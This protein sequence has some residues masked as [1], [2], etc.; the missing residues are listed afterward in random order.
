MCNG[1]TRRPQTEIKPW[2]PWHG[3][4]K[5]SEGCRN[6][7]VY[8][9]DD[10]HNKSDS[11]IVRKNADF[12]LPVR[13]DKNGRFKLI[14]GRGYVFTCMTSDFFV[15][16]ADLWRPEAWEMIKSRS[17]INFFIITKRI[18]RFAET[19]P[20]DWGDGYGNVTI[21]CTMENQEAV[22]KRLPVFM[23]LPIKHKRI[24]CEP[25][26]ERICFGDFCGKAREIEAVIAGGES[27]LFEEARACDYEWILDIRR[28]CAEYGISFWFKQTGANFIRDG[29]LYRI[30]RDMQHKQ[31]VRADIN[32][33]H[34]FLE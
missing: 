12:N 16:D 10:A 2:N 26:L 23:D 21:C 5:F 28:Q 13:K 15:E 17:D 3:C 29:R 18:H 27:G 14:C 33:E 24:A 11:F 8:R 31:A 22:R 25:L 20:P 6:C 9:I 34:G 7:Y 4:R 19:A 1:K 30:P 32:L